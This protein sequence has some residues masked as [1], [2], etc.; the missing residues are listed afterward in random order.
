MEV[1]RWLNSHC[2]VRVN[3]FCFYQLLFTHYA[4]TTDAAVSGEQSVNDKS[5]LQCVDSPVHS[6]QSKDPPI[7]VGRT[8]RRKQPSPKRAVET[9]PSPVK[10]KRGRPPGRKNRC[11]TL[12]LTEMPQETLQEVA[13]ELISEDESDKEAD[14][15]DV[16]DDDDD[17]EDYLP[18]AQPKAK[19][20]YTFV[21]RKPRKAAAPSGPKSSVCDVCGEI[22]MT[23][24]ELKQH[25]KKHE[26]EK[27]TC[28]E[29]GERLDGYSNLQQHVQAMHKKERL[30][31][32]NIC[33]E[34]FTIATY[35][36]LH[37]EI[38]V[39]DSDKNLQCDKCGKKFKLSTTLKAHVK[40][41]HRKKVYDCETCGRKFSKK[42]NLVVH[43]RCHTGEKP[44][45][46]DQCGRTFSQPSTLRSHKL[47]HTGER[48]FKC[49]V[50]DFA[51]VRADD[52]KT[53]FRRHTGERPFQCEICGKRFSKNQQMVD[54]KR[55]H[56][57]DKRF[58]CQ[59]C[60]GMFFKSSHLKRHMTIHSGEKPFQCQVCGK[61][62]NRADNLRAHMKV[63]R[64]EVDGENV[65][66]QAKQTK[67]PARNIIE[68][69]TNYDNDKIDMQQQQHR[70][71]IPV[72]YP[73]Q[74]RY[75]G[76][77]MYVVPRATPSTAE[78][79]RAQ[80]HD[81]W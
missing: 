59:L 38:H 53:H 50:C 71:N 78:T 39:P 4:S 44:Y 43:I 28:K 6:V 17:D 41:Y 45:K 56:T 63:H 22:F 62:V 60:G 72:T 3:G 2:H 67:T 12:H 26:M 46:C 10:R 74:L 13:N 54:H 32:C 37:R 23:V 52:L 15:F 34:T 73:A 25:K 77:T 8:R 42:S 18:T 40:M 20:K 79:S 80:Q 9:T 30:F 19:R 31:Q 81:Q 21:V 61:K 29:C 55:H 69:T 27:L 65:T 51:F 68:S 11:K 58:K 75:E 57:G 76:D 70:T 49:S 33:E 64:K 48:P 66:K 16:A 47:I 5:H 24:Q 14:Y 36:T 1:N 35:L 7:I